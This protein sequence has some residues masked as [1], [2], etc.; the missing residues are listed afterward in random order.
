MT[1]DVP[2]SRDAPG[3]P[4]HS[5]PTR[6]SSI[7]MQPN[8]SGSHLRTYEAIFRHPTAHNLEWHDVLSMLG[9]LG[10]VVEEHNGK[11]QATMGGQTLVLHRPKGKDVVSEDELRKLRHFLDQTPDAV[12]PTAASGTHML[13]VIDHREAR[14]YATDLQGSVPA[15]IVPDDPH[16]FDR[17]L[18]N[19]QNDGDGKRR[20][21]RKEFYEAIAKAVRGAHSILLF[22]GGTG[23]SSAMDHLLAELKHSHP[24]E[25]KHVVGTLTI[26]EKHVTEGELL[27][28]ARAFHASLAP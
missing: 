9:A 1:R 10:E 3:L 5:T 16:G 17:E 13:V 14:V 4:H 26:D 12:R 24:E 11:L 22:G 18:R 28:K 2:A 15:R 27:A 20:P 19:D 23:E 7:P 21:E 6:G 25:A 8:L